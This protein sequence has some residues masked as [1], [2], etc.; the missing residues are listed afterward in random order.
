MKFIAAISN[1]PASS[2]LSL[3][4]LMLVL[5]ELGLVELKLSL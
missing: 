5:L 3:L 4:V 1:V 2:Q